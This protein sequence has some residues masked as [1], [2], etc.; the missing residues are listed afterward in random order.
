MLRHLD[1]GKYDTCLPMCVFELLWIGGV[2]LAVSR[3]IRRDSRT[4]DTGHSFLSFLLPL[5]ALLGCWITWS[6]HHLLLRVSRL[7]N[8]QP[9]GDSSVY[10]LPQ[11]KSHLMF[12][13]QLKFSKKAR[14]EI[15]QIAPAP[16]QEGKS[17]NFREIIL[18]LES[19]PSTIISCVAVELQSF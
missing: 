14:L 1:G 2:G 3:F 5:Y 6:Y 11:L 9:T 16:D 15:T 12:L 10:P 13:H 4:P 8:H 17:L 7:V 18:A 19:N